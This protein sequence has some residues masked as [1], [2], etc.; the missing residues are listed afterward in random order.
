MYH[1]LGHFHHVL[2]RKVEVRL[3][4]PEWSIDRKGFHKRRAWRWQNEFFFTTPKLK[5]SSFTEISPRKASTM[6][7]E[8]IQNLKYIPMQRTA[9][10][11]I[12]NHLLGPCMLKFLGRSMWMQHS[13]NPVHWHQCEW[14]RNLLTEKV[15]KTCYFPKF[16]ICESL[17]LNTFA[18]MLWS[19]RTFALLTSRWTRGWTPPV[20]K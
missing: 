16:L 1:S 10:D 9:Y 5:V 14:V 19:R 17:L 6:S 13:L 12:F 18:F 7:G 20:C 4:A 8:I 3:T 2:H 15:N 11:F